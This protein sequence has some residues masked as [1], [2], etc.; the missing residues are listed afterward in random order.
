MHKYKL[1]PKIFNYGLSIE[2][3]F[4]KDLTFLLLGAPR[5]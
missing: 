3:C 1:T 2:V 4:I 5:L